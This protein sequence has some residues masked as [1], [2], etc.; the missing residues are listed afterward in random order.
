MKID[1][2]KQKPFSNDYDQNSLCVV[3][4]FNKKLEAL[5]GRHAWV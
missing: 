2:E 3:R 1:I 4:V 5:G